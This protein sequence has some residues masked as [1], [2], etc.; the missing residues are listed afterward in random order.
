MQ[1]L[2]VVVLLGGLVLAL[3]GY[4][5]ARA[6]SAPPLEANIITDYRLRAD[7]GFLEQQIQQFLDQQPGPLKNYSETIYTGYNQSAARS[8]AVFSLTAELNPKVLLTI[9]EVKSKL[10]STPTPPQSAIDFALGFDKLDRK[11]FSKQLVAAAGLL[12]DRWSYYDVN[13][14]LIFKDGSTAPASPLINRGTY[15]VQATLAY[16]ADPA[17]WEYQAGL[18]DGSF[19]QTYKTFF[20]DPLTPDPRPTGTGQ[21]APAPFLTRPFNPADLRLPGDVAGLGRRANAPGAPASDGLD[22]NSPLD[23]GINTYFDHEYPSNLAGT[24]GNPPDNAA[25]AIFLAYRGRE[26]PNS[27]TWERGYSGHNGIDF[28]LAGGTPVLAAASGRVV[29][30]DWGGCG[31]T[32]ILDHNN[33]YRTLYLHL[34]GAV[35]VGLGQEVAAGQPVGRVG[36]LNCT[37]SHLHFGVQF[38]FQHVDPFGFCPN[39]VTGDPWEVKS[40]VKSFWLW[41]EAPSPCPQQHPY[42]AGASPQEVAR[43]YTNLTLGQGSLEA[44]KPF[45]AE[46]AAA[47]T[48]AISPDNASSR[49]L[50]KPVLTAAPTANPGL[51]TGEAALPDNRTAASGGK[52]AV[53]LALLNDSDSLV[54]RSA[55][56]TLGQMGAREAVPRLLGLLKDPDSL[57][58]ASASKALLALDAREQ[59]IATCLSLLVDG[60]REVRLG[61]AAGLRELGDVRTIAALTPLLSQPDPEIRGLAEEVRTFLK[62]KYLALN[63]ALG[64]KA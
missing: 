54:R 2:A 23:A 38:N 7:E 22:Y 5:P 13:T 3:D 27:P 35:S 49:Q 21:T 51:P 11:G 41:R 46:P 19:Y 64:S 4:S 52:A 18:G 55:V 9:L 17:A 20:G 56:D 57:V 36:R 45:E 59:T 44:A 63:V 25:P 31:K 33:G 12:S 50:D 8:L 15:A 62:I 24:P 16:T 28:N 26:V 48:P 40:G 32:V 42:A 14:N 58:R 53:Y 1:A 61:A 10:L 34:D 6:D 43:N 37:P 30:A 29:S 47:P 60:D 39:T